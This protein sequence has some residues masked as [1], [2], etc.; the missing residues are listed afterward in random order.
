MTDTEQAAALPASAAPGEPIAIVAMSR[1]LPGGV[2]DTE[3]LWRLLSGGADAV[4]AGRPRV[5]FLVGGRAFD[6]PDAPSRDLP[7]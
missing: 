6:D 4:T 1:R 7:G 3:S 5:G 2:T